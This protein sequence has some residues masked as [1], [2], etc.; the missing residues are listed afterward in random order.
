[1]T[2]E[3]TQGNLSPSKPPAFQPRELDL[4]SFALMLLRHLHFILGC[5]LIACLGMVADMLHVKPRYAATA[6]MIVPQGNLSAAR[7]GQQLS[8][9][10]SDLLGGGYELYTDMVKSRTIAD[11]LID[12]YDLKSV[13]AARD[14]DTAESHLASMTTVEAQRDGLIRVTVQDTSRQRA[15]ALANDYLHQLD[16]LNSRL[17]LTSVG[18]ERAYLE[19]ELFKEKDS[20]ADAEV[21]L[22]EVQE[23]TSGVPP[24]AAASAQLG[25][26]ESTRAQL[27]A[28]QIHLAALLTGD[29]D[30]NPEVV[31]LRSEIAGLFSQLEE[32]QR[33][34]SSS[35]NGTPTSQVPEQA[36]TY[37]RRFRDVKFHEELYDL[38]EKQFEEAKQ[39]E[40]KTPSIV[41]V[42]DPAVP[43]L[44]RAWPRRTYS[45][46]MAAIFG[47]VTGIFLVSLWALILAYMRNPA[48]AEKLQQL[49]TLYRR[50][51]QEQP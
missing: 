12:D 17:V 15:A 33:G 27:R 51:S 18:E 38:L 19:R 42:L 30:A 31:R 36:L 25:A 1:M 20:L 48:N 3:P 24:E 6:V 47:T 34:V 26:L 45:C 22:K 7:L 41:Q 11:R 50:Q 10:T 43:S 5:G 21:A 28:D 8:L 40:A 23:N 14:L 37:T 44:H 29:T 9:G 16:L 46:I 2:P 35:S 49:K 4:F 32:L 39:Q 13:Y